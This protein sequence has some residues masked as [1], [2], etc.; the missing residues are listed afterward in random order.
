MI[1]FGCWRLNALR[2]IKI[3]DKSRKDKIRMV[4]IDILRTTRLEFWMI[5]FG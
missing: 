1:D 4:I 2:L 3:K 5:D